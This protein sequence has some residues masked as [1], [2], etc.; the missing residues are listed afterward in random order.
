MQVLK[1][2]VVSKARRV[3]KASLELREPTVRKDASGPKEMLVRPA[4]MDRE[5]QPAPMALPVL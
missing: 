2:Y 4:R 3:F 1:E 5:A